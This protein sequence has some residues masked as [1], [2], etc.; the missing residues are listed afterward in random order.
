[1][2]VT[3]ICFKIRDIASN[4]KDQFDPISSQTEVTS[5]YPKTYHIIFLSFIV[6]LN[7]YQVLNVY[8]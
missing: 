8:F 3:I 1:M 2:H 7:L 6:L 4:F 5:H